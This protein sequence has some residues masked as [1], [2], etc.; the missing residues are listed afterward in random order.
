MSS[1]ELILKGSKNGQA[2]ASAIEIITSV[3]EDI[4]DNFCKYRETS[5]E[6]CECDHI[7]DGNQC[8]LDK[9]V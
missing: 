6:N 5:D 9:L 4:C 8:P 7:R 2:S 1:I 3:A